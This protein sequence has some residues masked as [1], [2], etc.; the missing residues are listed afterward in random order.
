M[1]DDQQQH[2]LR[3][4]DCSLG[5]T[6]MFFKCSLGVESVECGHLVR[7]DECPT[8]STTGDGGH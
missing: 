3:G 2:H 8:R 1:Q 4:M 5:L 6:E 7:Q